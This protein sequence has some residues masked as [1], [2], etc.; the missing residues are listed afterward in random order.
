M[1]L[2]WW[3]DRVCMVPTVDNVDFLRCRRLMTVGEHE[4]PK[5]RTPLSHV[6]HKGRDVGQVLM[7]FL[8]K[9]MGRRKM[10]TM[11]QVMG[12]L[13]CSTTFNS[14]FYSPVQLRLARW[15]NYFKDANVQTWNFTELWIKY[16]SWKQSTDKDCMLCL[17]V[18]RHWIW[19][20]LGF[21]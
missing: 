12:K 13:K 2:Q 14:N 8:V 4:A 15:I 17:S 21:E 1:H 11:L 16:H 20:L 9:G 6:V 10:I 19:R 3:T 7:T 18:S 5:A